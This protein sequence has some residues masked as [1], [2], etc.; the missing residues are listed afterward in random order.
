MVQLPLET[1]KKF[2]TSISTFF[3]TR[4]PVQSCSNENAVLQNDISISFSILHDGSQ[5]DS[6]SEI[7]LYIE[8]KYV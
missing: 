2:H 5:Q 7:F 6:S 3:V 1:L 8:V 4:R